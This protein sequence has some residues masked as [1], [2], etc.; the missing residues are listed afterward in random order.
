MGAGTSGRIAALDAAE[1]APTFGVP[2]ERVLVLLAGGKTAAARAAEEAEDDRSAA[3][4]DLEDLN[5]R[6]HDVVVGLAASGST[7]YV[8]SAIRRASELGCATVSISNNADAELSGVAQVAIE[9]VTGPEILTGSTRL[10]A[11]TSQ[12]LVLNMLST[13]AFTCLGKVYGNFMVDLQA[14]NEKLK[15]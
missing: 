8:V 10:K 11:G 1:C 6:P 4:Q 12:K 2:P 13:T 9:V 3:V 5:L 15:R 14:S 7:P